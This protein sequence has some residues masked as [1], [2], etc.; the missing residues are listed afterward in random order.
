MRVQFTNEENNIINER[1]DKHEN[2]DGLV[3]PVESQGQ[4]ITM[5]LMVTDVHKFNMFVKDWIEDQGLE[6]SQIANTIG[7]DITHIDLRPPIQ[8]D[9]LVFLQNYINSMLYGPMPTPP[10]QVQEE[11]MEDI[12]HIDLGDD[13][14]IKEVESDENEST[15]E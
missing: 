4:V 8:S 2:V 14:T 10:V 7:A 1:R 9:H 15:P 6:D 13:V 12:E 3:I 11:D 5:G